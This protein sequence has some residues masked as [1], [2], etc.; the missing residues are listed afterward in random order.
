MLGAVMFCSKL[1]MEM[2]PNIHLLGVLTMVYTVAFR[3]KALIPLYIYVIL[4]GVYY[5][6]NVWWFPYLYIW[7]VLWAITMLLPKN[8]PKKARYIVYPVICGLHGLAFGT[9]YAPAY[10]LI[11]KMN[12]QQTLGWIGAG[13]SFDA[14]HA[15]SNFALGF[16]IVPL[17][18]LLTNL[19]K[20]GEPQEK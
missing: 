3:A 5:G 12:F 17:S 19:M 1:V 4:H 11:M 9:L 2:L 13:L 15:A 6:F 14:I 8:M 10:A 20:K 7:A 16:L 18:E